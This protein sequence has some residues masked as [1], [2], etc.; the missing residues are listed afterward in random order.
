MVTEVW[1][2]QAQ[3]TFLLEVGMALGLLLSIAVSSLPY[4]SS[5]S[6]AGYPL[7]LIRVWTPVKDWESV[8]GGWD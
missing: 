3:L 8:I 5:G 2:S 1:A 4:P 6:L 7:V